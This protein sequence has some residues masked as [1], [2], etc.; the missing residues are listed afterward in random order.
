MRGRWPRL[1]WGCFR[2]AVRRDLQFRSQTLIN[3]LSSIGDL[4]LGIVP[5]LILTGAG[6]TAWTGSLAVVVVGIYGI[7][8]GLM[9]C[10]VTPNLAKIDGYVRQ[11]DLDLILVRPVNAQ[12]FTALRWMEP[13]ELGRVASGFALVLAGLHTAGLQP[14]PDLVLRALAWAAIG[15]VGFSLLWANLVYLAFWF[16]SAE[17]VNEIAL[18]LREAGKYPISYFSG[19]AR[20]VLS[21]VAPA[22]LI[23]AVPVQTLTGTT[24]HLLLAL[25]A[26]V[27][28]LLLTV[29]HW[30][31]ASRRYSSASS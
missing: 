16:D 23:A 9:D 31:L 30:Q 19:P 13:A 7:S 14:A 1:L 6:G 29:L 15:F 22:G 5:V 26:L 28:G 3:A 2:Q 27:V 25:P 21:T 11:G 4:A 24:S 20:L 18:Q 8:T 12:L 17:P 10:F